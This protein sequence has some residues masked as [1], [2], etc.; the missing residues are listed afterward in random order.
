ML[1]TADV[2]TNKFATWDA[3]LPRP[4]QN[5][6]C[7]ELAQQLQVELQPPHQNLS[8][9]YSHSKMEEEDEDSMYAPAESTVTGQGVHAVNGTGNAPIKREGRTDEEEGE[10][11][12][13]EVE[14]DESDSVGAAATCFLTKPLN[15][16]Q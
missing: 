12:G 11:E 14:E 9:I 6:R 1:K 13:E 7:S 4:D 2:Q 5:G 16:M 15:V 8:R 10:E 3:I